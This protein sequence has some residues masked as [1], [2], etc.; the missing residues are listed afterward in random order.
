VL[1]ERRRVDGGAL[2][3][4]AVT[5]GATPATRTLHILVLTDRDWTHPQG[6]GTGTNLYGQV[7]R[8]I[9]WGHRVTVIGG[10]YPGARRVERP[11]PRLTLH[12][13]G[14][15]R[16]VFPRAA[17][18]VL[19]RRVGR[20]ADVV[21][22]VINGI[23]FFTPLWLRR[24]RVALVHHVHRDMYVAELGRRGA[25]A[26]LLLE[27]LPLRFL[28]RSTPFITIS[29]AAQR[30]LE[31]LGVPRE[32]VHVA[33]LGV[34]RQ[35]PWPERRAE[36]PTLLYLGRLK[37]YK[38]IERV[39]DVLEAVPEATLDVAGD[40]AHRPALEAEIARRGLTDRVRMHGAV[41]E[42]QKAELYGRAWVALTT[43]SAEGWC[44]TVMEAAACGTP[45]AA[46]RVGGLPESIVDGQ[47]GVLADTTPELA[48]RVRALVRDPAERDRLGAAARE[49]A[50]EFTWERTA[51]ANLAV[52]E[53]EA[54]APREPLRAT[55]LRSET[56]KAAGLAS[57]LMA[58]NVIS[59]LFTVVFARLLGIKG[60]GSL[61]ALVSTFLILSV[62]GLA[63][64]VAAARET[65]LG[66]LGAGGAL[67]RTHRRW[68]LQLGGAFALL[69]GVG[70]VLRHPLAHAIGVEQPWAAGAT[71]ATGCAWLAL[72]LERGV[73]QGLRA[74]KVAG[75]SVVAEASSR[76]L[77]GLVLVGA[78]AGVSGAYLASP[79]SMVAVATVLAVILRRRLGPPDAAATPRRLDS[80]IA[81]A[82]A[83]V[84]GL[85][86]IA[87]LQN[88]DVII[89]KH[90][91]GGKGAGAYAAAAV[92]AKVVI[93]V[94]IGLAYYLVP[95]AARRASAGH[96]ARGVLARALAIILAVAAP[97]LLVYA[98]VP[99]L[100]LSI[101]FGIHFP[102][103]N[104]ALVVLGAAMSLLAIG[105]LA[106][107]YM[108]AI[109]QYAFMFVLGAV[110]AIEPLLLSNAGK[111]LVGLATLV[112]GLQC[113]AASGM[114]A[115][116]LRGPRR[117]AAAAS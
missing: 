80:L 58:A 56:A 12:H 59:L 3:S 96:S 82:W 9:E 28:Y 87:V 52:L 27:T 84:L 78:G 54:G 86:L 57:A 85:T 108:L 50:H 48:A 45:S 116:S 105:S 89:V 61:A 32:R 38:R 72:S 42:R 112:L 40:G 30:D 110:A 88:I 64:Q 117:A 11:H 44:L 95:E 79:L 113:L 34:E 91:V 49:R 77:A 69:A 114:L 92:A 90:R 68:M 16:T 2:P 18:A 33:Y 4:A 51:S 65:A 17:W 15:R 99:G 22:E 76:L 20:D 81:G 60:Y 43:S 111:G 1:R 31:A 25:L 8:W 47:T 93:W 5:D 41:T 75:V 21:L 55:L 23:A 109:E 36:R 83:P 35:A 104:H 46:L 29:Q 115:L 19:R 70:V 66:R 26:A 107:Q 67:A 106:V 94:G 53:R 62:P 24:P 63:L 14:T 101:G 71:L 73:L 97:M 37:Q 98:A 7:S 74:Y 100:V 103:V 6:G 39:L 13:M 10:D 102:A